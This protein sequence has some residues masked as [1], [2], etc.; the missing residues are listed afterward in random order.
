[1]GRRPVGSCA[2]CRGPPSPC[3]RHRCPSCHASSTF[4]TSCPKC[5]TLRFTSQCCIFSASR[6]L[7]ATPD[8]QHSNSK[9]ADTL[10]NPTRPQLFLLLMSSK[11]THVTKRP[12]R[13]PK[14][15]ERN[16]HRGPEGGKSVLFL[17][18]LLGRALSSSIHRGLWI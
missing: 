7:A 12:L 5:W 1:M 4:L 6:S 15:T 11:C 16:V 2:G 14:K 9:N 8:P 17:R 13:C 18:F 10:S 3:S